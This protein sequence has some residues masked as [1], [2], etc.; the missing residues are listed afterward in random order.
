MDSMEKMDEE[1]N[2]RD[3]S[4]ESGDP[5]EESPESDPPVIDLVQ[6]KVTDEETLQMISEELEMKNKAIETLQQEL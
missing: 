1:L 5:S 3:E 4:G 2:A 6:A